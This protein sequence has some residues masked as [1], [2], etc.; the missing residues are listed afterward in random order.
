MRPCTWMSSSTDMLEKNVHNRVSL[1]WQYI[2]TF[3]DGKVVQG[4]VDL[5]YM[6]T[7]GQKK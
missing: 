6:M 2:Y 3:T 7:S 5:N 4:L 1:N